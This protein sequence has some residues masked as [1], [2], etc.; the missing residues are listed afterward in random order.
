MP[1]SEAQKRATQNFEKQVYKKILLRIR[2][3]GKSDIVN[4]KE[5][6]NAVAKSGKSL[7][8]YILEA[9]KEKIVREENNGRN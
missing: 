2:Q 5:L 9:I 7:N 3:D 1:V 6:E 4:Y 8:G